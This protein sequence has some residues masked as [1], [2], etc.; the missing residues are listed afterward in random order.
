MT[1]WTSLPI[2]ALNVSARQEAIARQQQLTKPHGSLG[3]LENIVI[4]LAAMQGKEPKIN[5][6][7]ITVFAGDHGIAAA[8]VSAFPQEVTGQMVA[9]FA[10]GGAAI[11][12]LAK[13]LL[14]PFEIV[15]LGTVTPTNFAGVINRNIAPGTANML[16]TDA[17]TKQQCAEALDQGRESLLNAV[18]HGCELFIGGEMGI[19]NT[20]SATVLACA[21]SGMSAASLTGPGTGLDAEGVARKVGIIEQVLLK[22]AGAVKKPLLLLQKVGGLEIAALVGSYITAAQEGIPILVDGFICTAAAMVA[23]AIAPESRNWMIFSH[24]SAE[25]GHKMMLQYLSVEPLLDLSLR[26]GEGSGAALS[27]PLIRMACQ[28][29]SEMATFEEAA[30]AGKIDES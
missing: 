10:N 8:G 9:N 7:F 13:A 1:T 22:H 28:L 4:Q 15:N 30:I 12:V 18:S 11:S 26:L 24:G 17:M 19:G 16:T 29:H 6:A 20:T 23:I 3:Q 2:K 14:A 21:L 27:V 25:P 5:T